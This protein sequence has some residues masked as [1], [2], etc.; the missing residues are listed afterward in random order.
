MVKREAETYLEKDR[1]GDQDLDEDM[2]VGE[3]EDF[4]VSHI[5]YLQWDLYI[6]TAA[7]KNV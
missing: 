3:N 5:H 7:N 1:L 4:G 6:C 2:N